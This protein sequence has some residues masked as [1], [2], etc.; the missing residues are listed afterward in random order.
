MF[1]TRKCVLSILTVGKVGIRVIVWY[2]N[3][4]VLSAFGFD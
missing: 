4:F 2:V 1:G 3:V